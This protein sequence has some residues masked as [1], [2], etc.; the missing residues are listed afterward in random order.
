MAEVIHD[1]SLSLESTTV[2]IFRTATVIKGGRR[3]SFGAL[4]V[5]GDRQGSVG[6]GY[7]KAPGVPAAIEKAQKDARKKLAKITLLE[8]TI[9]HTMNS[10][11]AASNVRLVPAAPGTGVIA[12]ATVRAVLELA[13]VRDCLTKV[14]GSS[15]RKNLCKATFEGLRKL[16]SKQQIEE[17]RGVSVGATEVEQ[18]LEA[19]RRYAPVTS[20]AEPAKAPQAPRPAGRGGKGGGGRGRRRGPES[21][22]GGGRG[23]AQPLAQDVAPAPAPDAAAASPAAPP[24]APQTE[25]PPPAGEETQS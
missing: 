19:G 3:F 15:N 22:G 7:G 11:F 23:G 5:I 13:G 25:A 20:G 12:G 1:E 18:R 2:G 21:G 24:P 14:Y 9:P 17:L 16:R 6:V 8:G 10:R 4:V